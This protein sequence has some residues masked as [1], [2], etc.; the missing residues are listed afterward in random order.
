MMVEAMSCW[1][2]G[3]S[4]SDR[5]VKASRKKTSQWRQV[6][7]GHGGAH[8]GKVILLLGAHGQYGVDKGYIV[9]KSLVLP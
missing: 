9:T 1:E 7:F 6:E 5:D 2:R 8:S 3:L 4:V